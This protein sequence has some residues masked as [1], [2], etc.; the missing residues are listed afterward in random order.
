MRATGYSMMGLVAS[1]MLMGNIN[2]AWADWQWEA[3]S[4]IDPGFSIGGDNAAQNAFWDAGIPAY[5]VRYPGTGSLTDRVAAWKATGT[6]DG[7]FAVTGRFDYV[8]EAYSFTIR[9]TEPGYDFWSETGQFAGMGMGNGWNSGITVRSQNG[10]GTY[11]H[12]LL[13][14]HPIHPSAGHEYQWEFGRQAGSLYGRVYE[15]VGGTPQLLAGHSWSSHNPTAA[16]TDVYIMGIGDWLWGDGE[17]QLTTMS[18]V[19]EPASAVLMAL[20]G[21]SAFTRR[22]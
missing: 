21:L 9:L 6:F 15:V 8:T 13:L 18:V 19:P 4:L 7:D 20:A 22:R 1:V 17:V 3:S 14:N 12:D 16:L 11:V 5:V 10:S 2:I